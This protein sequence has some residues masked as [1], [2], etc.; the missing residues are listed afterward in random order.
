MPTG[1]QNEPRHVKPLAQPQQSRICLNRTVPFMARHSHLEEEKSCWTCPTRH[2]VL[3]NHVM[4]HGLDHGCYKP[5]RLSGF[6]H[7]VIQSMESGTE[8]MVEE[9]E[10]AELIE[11]LTA[12]R[13]VVLMVRFIKGETSVAEATRQQGMIVVEIED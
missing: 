12:N 6:C 3:S 13:R 11:R 1:K 9:V 7:S 10:S 5:N 8:E 2:L 4:P